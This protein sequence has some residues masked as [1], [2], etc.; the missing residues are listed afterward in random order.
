MIEAALVSGIGTP[1]AYGLLRGMEK[2]K[3][4]ATMR[5]YA[6]IGL[7]AFAATAIGAYFLQPAPI[8]GAAVARAVGYPSIS[9]S[10]VTAQLGRYAGGIDYPGQLTGGA[11]SNGSLVYI[12]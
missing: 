6:V 2:G 10:D 7:A 12:D 8:N 9:V 1:V 3:R 4:K 11:G 5:E